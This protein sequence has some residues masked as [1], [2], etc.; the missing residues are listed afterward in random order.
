MKIKCID[1]ENP[2]CKRCRHMRLQCRFAM[3]PVP[4]VVL[5]EQE[6]TKG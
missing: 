4:R 1:K 6:A 3:A 5:E 2:P